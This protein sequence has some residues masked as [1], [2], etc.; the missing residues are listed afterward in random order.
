MRDETNDAMMND[1]D[2]RGGRDRR[3]RRPPF[4]KVCKFCTSPQGPDYK[5]PEQLRR[6]IPS[7]ARFFPLASLETAPSTNG[8]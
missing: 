3:A 5:N 4:E 6:Y 2:G 7:A 8:L 1:M